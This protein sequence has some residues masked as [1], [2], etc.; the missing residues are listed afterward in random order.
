ME[1]SEGNAGYVDGRCRKKIIKELIEH[2][3]S[4]RFH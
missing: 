1:I 3:N 2:K 4:N